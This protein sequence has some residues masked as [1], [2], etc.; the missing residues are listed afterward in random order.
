MI[1]C[2]IPLPIFSGSGR[3]SGTVPCT[4]YASVLP[5]PT[6]SSYLGVLPVALAG[7]DPNNISKKKVIQKAPSAVV[8]VSES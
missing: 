1:V 6:K 5:N 2:L 8:G 7:T 3:R 4:A